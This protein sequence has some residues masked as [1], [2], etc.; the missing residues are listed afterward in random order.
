V[1]KEPTEAFLRSRKYISKSEVDTQRYIREKTTIP[2]PEIFHHDLS[3]DGGGVGAPYILMEGIDGQRLPTEFQFVPLEI[4]EKI[5]RQVA[6]VVIQL[7]D[8]TFPKIGLLRFNNENELVPTDWYDELGFRHSPCRT[9]SSYYK[10]IYGL[11][12]ART[13]S[14]TDRDEKAMAWIWDRCSMHIRATFGTQGPFPLCHGDLWSGNFLWDDQFNLVAVIDWTR[15]MAMPWETSAMIREFYLH[16]AQSVHLVRQKFGNI[17]MTE[18]MKIGRAR[19]VADLFF[20]P[21]L[22]VL[23]L[24]KDLHLSVP[25][26]SLSVPRL[27]ALM[28]GHVEVKFLD[29]ISPKYI[30]R[31]ARYREKRERRIPTEWI[32]YKDVTSE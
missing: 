8:L 11:L 27:I 32:S 19:R 28:P 17:V 16:T 3:Y 10:R 7:S 6:R 5:Y 18:E 9:T 29:Y 13:L 31:C 25:D 26:A 12:R 4:Q 20:S 24:I 22:T 1:S 14:S 30:E 23:C 21:A 15:T 2:V